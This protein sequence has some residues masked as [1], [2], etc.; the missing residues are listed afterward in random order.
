MYASRRLVLAAFAVPNDLAVNSGRRYEGPLYQVLPTISNR[1]INE[2]RAVTFFMSPECGCKSY[3][4]KCEYL[5]LPN[6][7]N[8]SAKDN[9]E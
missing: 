3:P 2:E 7:K 4:S 6:L 5:K 9:L 8:K 1:T